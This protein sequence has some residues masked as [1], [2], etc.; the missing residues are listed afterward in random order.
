MLNGK[1]AEWDKMLN[2][3]MLNGT[4]R[5]IENRKEKCKEMCIFKIIL[6]FEKTMGH[7]MSNKVENG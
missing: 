1:M 7:Y 2:E 6:F 5:R 4:K 3:K